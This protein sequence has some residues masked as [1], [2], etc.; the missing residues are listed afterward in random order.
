VSAAPAL[1][2][3]VA[4]RD[5]E[6]IE[7]W[8][9]HLADANGLTTAALLAALRQRGVST[10][11]LTLAPG[12]DTIR[13][14]A[15]LARVCEHEVR[16][17]TLAA[18]DGTALDLTGLDPDD[19]HS[20]R[21]VAAR[22]WAPAH[23]TQACPAC[24]AETGTWRSAWRLRIVTTCT[25]HTTLLVTRCPACQRPLRDQRHSHLRTV[26][27]ATLCSNPLGA[28]P[29]RQC[30]HDLTTITSNPADTAVMA[31]Q[32]R[33]DAALA[34]EHVTTLGVQSQ[35]ATYLGDLRHLTTLLLHLGHQPGADRLAPWVPLLTASTSDRGGQRGPRWGLR[36]P[37]TAG[38]RAQTL[39]TADAMLAASD[40][41]AAVEAFQPWVELTPNTPDGVLGWLADRTVMTPT[42]T[43]LVMAARA[44]Q[45]RLS[46]HLDTPR[47]EG[48][49]MPINLL[50]IPQVIPH[51]QYVEHLTGVFD[52]SEVTVRLFASLSLARLHPD[53]TSW[54]AAAEA[55]AMPGPIGVRCARAC[56]ATM[57]VAADEWEA[58]TRRAI[59]EAPRENYRA[60]EAKIRH[61]LGMSRWYDE[62]ARRYRP[63][64][65]HVSYD[66]G[67][68]WL[69]VHVAHG[70]LDLSPA[71]R[72]REPSSKD[73]APYRKFESSLNQE[74]Q[75]E[76]ANAVYKRA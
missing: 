56:S 25:R 33:V 11:Y 14:L 64:T 7:S 31:T 60:L 55:L 19:R 41:D 63:G 24:L 45:R 54:A 76:L 58:R 75:V 26:G 50:A 9:E 1:P 13:A 28:G 71:W 74:Q 59:E 62:W 73:R 72:G 34:G 8:L 4:P 61:S 6:S 2:V 67:L 23:G 17:T 37:T 16:A 66:L 15:G 53:V 48:V 3:S 12:P 44:P 46:H 30:Q 27:A 70:H 69:W 57:L 29:T 52:S 5:G 47:T 21:Q 49:R 10:R 22:G 40:L 38:L 36:P 39:S 65:R 43:R 20:Y 42:L 51:E 32:E 35:P 68:S 18:Y